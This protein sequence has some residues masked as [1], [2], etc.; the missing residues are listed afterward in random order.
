MASGSATGVLYHPQTQG[1]DER[2]HRLLK[3][4]VLDRNSF[5]DLTRV[6][7]PSTAM[8]ADP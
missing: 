5:A 4:E 3:A 6:R 8:A 2:F 1:K 7:A